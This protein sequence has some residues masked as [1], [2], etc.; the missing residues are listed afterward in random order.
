MLTVHWPARSPPRAQ[1]PAPCPDTAATFS[2][3]FFQI[4]A[5]AQAQP[6]LLTF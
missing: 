4:P 2:S 3:V 6:I 5:V 1:P